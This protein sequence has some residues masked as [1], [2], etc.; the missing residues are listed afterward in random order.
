MTVT[1]FFGAGVSRPSRFPVVCELTKMVLNNTYSRTIVENFSPGPPDAPE[2]D[3]THRVQKFLRVLYEYNNSFLSENSGGGRKTNYEDLYFLCDQIWRN[4]HGVSDTGLAWEFVKHI[5][6]ETEHIVNQENDFPPLD[7]G[8]FSEEA[9][10]LIQSV[11]WHAV[12]Q[13]LEKVCGLELLHEIANHNNIDQVYVITLNHDTLVEQYL[14]SLGVQ[15]VDGFGKVEG[16]VRWYNPRVYQTDH[17][18]VKLIKL[19]G[20]T[21]WNF[22]RLTRPDGSAVDRRAIHV[23]TYP[24]HDGAG[25]LLRRTS[26]IPM[27]LS[28]LGKERLY[29]SGIYGDMQDEF[30]R[31]LDR[32]QSILMSGYGWNDLGISQRLLRWLNRDPSRKLILLH[33]NP[34]EIR[35]ESRGMNAVDFEELENK[36]Q[37]IVIEKW[38]SDVRLN[39]IEEYLSS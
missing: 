1:L 7:I 26:S 16:D 15:Y 23:G 30:L 5:E 11:V 37:L 9:K 32:S 20:S 38:F 25:N 21:N 17:A 18:K 31:A 8:H 3:E 22:F 14:D 36:G 39:E 35:Y 10:M 28:E 4:F 19:H 2:F 12:G 13:T 29:N 6:S 33:Q 34:K 24:A 27:F